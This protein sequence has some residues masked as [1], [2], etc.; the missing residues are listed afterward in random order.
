M[1]YHGAFNKKQAPVTSSSPRPSCVC[2]GPSTFVPIVFAPFLVGFKGG[3]AEPTCLSVEDSVTY[4][5]TRRRG[6]NPSS[7]RLSQ[8][9]DEYA[10]ILMSKCH[11]RFPVSTPHSRDNTITLML[12]T[13]RPQRY[14]DASSRCGL[15]FPYAKFP[16]AFDFCFLTI[17]LFQD[18][19]SRAEL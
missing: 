11:N 6:P 1:E 15:Q 17:F 7:A 10:R 18:V 3:S 2:L 4:I 9:S 8:L 12:C 14:G 16:L 19:K 5:H 13:R